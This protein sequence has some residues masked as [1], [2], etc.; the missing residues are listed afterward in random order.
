MTFNPVEVAKDF[1]ILQRKVNGKRLAFLD[2]GA[3]AQKPG[4][5]IETMNQFLRQNYANVHRGIYTLDRN[6]QSYMK[7]HEKVAK[8]LATD[9]RQVIFV[10]GVTEGI[11]LVAQTWGR[12]T[13]QAG[14][15]ILLSVMEHHANIVPWQLLADQIGVVIKVVNLNA[16]GSLDLED[17]QAKLSPRTKLVA[18]M[19]MSNVLGTQVPIAQLVKWVRAR[20]DLAETKILIVLR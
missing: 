7:Q 6:H 11:N 17:F 8:F 12:A 4:A 1:P 2:S 19:H 16:D 5:V 18:I 9:A 20:P 15:E 14:D 10:R 13:L 3:S